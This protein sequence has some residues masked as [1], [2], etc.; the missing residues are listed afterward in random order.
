MP[1]RPHGAAADDAADAERGAE[2]YGFG[3]VYLSREAMLCGARGIWSCGRGA[4]ATAASGECGAGGD[5]G[6]E[7]VSARDRRRGEGGGGWG[8]AEAGEEPGVS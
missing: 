3:V 6:G 8:R 7:W 4:G 2:H 1:D 5:G